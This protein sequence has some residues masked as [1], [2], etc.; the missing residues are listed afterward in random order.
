MLLYEWFSFRRELK[1]RQDDCLVPRFY[2]VL[3][4]RVL[5]FYARFEVPVVKR[6]VS[7]ASGLSSH[8]AIRKTGIRC[9][10]PGIGFL[11]R[12]HHNIMMSAPPAPS[13][14]PRAP[15]SGVLVLPASCS[16]RKS[17]C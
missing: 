9:L 3:D 2:R 11:T 12:C 10:D 13:P 7:Q 8:E 14:S 1:T 15:L 5:R 16:G 6:N 4:C 17:R